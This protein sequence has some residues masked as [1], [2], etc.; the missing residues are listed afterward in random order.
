MIAMS[1]KEELFLKLEEYIDKNYMPKLHIESYKEEAPYMLEAQE[2]RAPRY[3]KESRKLKDLIE[4]EEETFSEMLL[5]LIDQKK[6]TD[7]DAYKNA[8]VDR[9]IMR[10][11]RNFSG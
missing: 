5:R 7:V 8:N 4:I 10:L 1:L 3:M 11:S 9:R 6:I 2:I